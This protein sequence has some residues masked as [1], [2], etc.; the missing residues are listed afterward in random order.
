MSTS[1]GVTGGKEVL[2]DMEG[3]GAGGE[4]QMS[5]FVSSNSY[6]LTCGILAT[7]PSEFTNTITLYELPVYVRTYTTLR[8][9]ISW[10]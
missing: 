10:R 2:Y 8:A 3:V 4:V 5:L 9:Q 6:K 7:P 1:A